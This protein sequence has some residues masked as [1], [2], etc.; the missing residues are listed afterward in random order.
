MLSKLLHVATISSQAV[1]N[2]DMIGYTNTLADLDVEI[3]AH[4]DDPN[5]IAIAD[6]LINVVSTYD[7]A[8]APQKLTV[9]ASSRSDHSSFWDCGYPAVMYRRLTPLTRIITR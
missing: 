4:P 1:I 7:L 6:V 8:L 2:L 5:S 3:H 9:N